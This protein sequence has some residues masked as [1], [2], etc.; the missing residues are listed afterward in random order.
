MT[1]PV[2]YPVTAAIVA[3]CA[4]IGLAPPRQPRIVGFFAYLCGFPIN[5]LPFIAFYY[6]CFSTLLA[7]QSD[8]NSPAGWIGLGTAALATATLLVVVLRELRVGPVL[9]R[10]LTEGLGLAITVGQPP[11]RKLS[12][13]RILAWPFLMRR[14]D[15]ERVA[16]ISYG[17]AAMRNR[18]DVYRSRSVP[19]NAP[20]F[21]HF[22]GGML[23]R[24]RKNREALPLLYQLASH[25]WVCI[26]ANL[27][28]SATR[29]VPRAP[30]RR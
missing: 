7:T 13:A 17:D 6:L 16:N 2:G 23:M 15:V 8:F 5:E 9:D 11:R 19:Q 27:P 10:A 21:V 24:G 25:G 4:L 22:Q 14:R 30:Y 12:Y 1:A 26:S 20:V 29:A 3:G 28:L 18:L